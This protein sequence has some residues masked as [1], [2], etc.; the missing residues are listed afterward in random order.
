MR[1]SGCWN[2]KNRRGKRCSKGCT[3]NKVDPFYFEDGILK[4][5][6]VNITGKF[7]ENTVVVGCG[8]INL[9]PSKVPFVFR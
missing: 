4:D 3:L 8:C 6:L 2:C 1:K 5:L 9:I 7:N